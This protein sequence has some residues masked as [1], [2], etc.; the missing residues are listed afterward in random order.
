M[1]KCGSSLKR[2]VIK[3]DRGI[4]R[5]FS[6]LLQLSKIFR[7]LATQINNY[8]DGYHLLHHSQFGLRRNFFNLTSAVIF[9]D[10][11]NTLR[12]GFNTRISLIWSKQLASIKFAILGKFWTGS[13]LTTLKQML[14]FLLLIVF[15]KSS[16]GNRIFWLIQIVWCLYWLL[17]LFKYPFYRTLQKNQPQRI[18]FSD[19]WLGAE[20]GL[21]DSVPSQ[22]D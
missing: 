17:T 20:S 22:S 1:E 18:F 10:E 21:A 3:T 4:Y 7:F 19:D 15:R 11:D 2:T 14:W 9:F 8:F 6:I 5:P 13:F 12:W 16:I